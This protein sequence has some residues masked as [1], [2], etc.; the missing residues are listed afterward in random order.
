MRLRRSEV[1]R[2][3]AIVDGHAEKPPQIVGVVVLDD[4]LRVRCPICGAETNACA[5]SAN[6]PPPPRRLQASLAWRSRQ[7]SMPVF[8][9]RRLA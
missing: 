4:D 8:A 2:H 5:F 1:F 7:S 3:Q 9:M 6:F